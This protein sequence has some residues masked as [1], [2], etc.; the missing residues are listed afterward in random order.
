MKPAWDK[1]MGEFKGSPSALV[2]DVD[3]TAAGEP[4]CSKH[5]VRGYP[6]IKYGS[7]DKLKDYQ[8]GRDF[9]SLKSFADKNLGPNCNADNLKVCDKATKE[10]YEKYL[11]MTTGDVEALVKEKRKEQK[12]L[13][14]EINVIKG[15][16]KKLRK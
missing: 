4:L 15:A 13:E 10:K 14:D 7:P 16:A 6:T 9:N 2:A 1:L 8:G 11:A 5:G 3:C 12:A